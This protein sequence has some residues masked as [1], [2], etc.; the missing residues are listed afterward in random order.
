MS[1]EKWQR[2]KD[3]LADTLALAA[4]DHFAF[5][6]TVCG[7]DTELRKEVEA[8]LAFE[9]QED[10]F[11]KK[12]A[13]DFQKSFSA[14][15]DL[16]QLIGGQIGSYKIIREIDSGG[17]GAVYLAERS[18]DEFQKQVAIKIIKRGMDTNEILRRFRTERQLLANLDHPNIARLL[19]GGTA[20]DGLP[21]F[22]MEYIEGQPLDKY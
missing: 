7:T 17:I 11:L 3:I 16:N 8:F 4:P 22:V 9:N 21:Y 12:P 2:V 6:E 15:S 19:D 20:T 1:P 18:D 14:E 13:V 10:S 5:L